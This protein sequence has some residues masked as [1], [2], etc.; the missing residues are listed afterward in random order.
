IGKEVAEVKSRPAKDLP[1][2]DEDY[3]LYK[4]KSGDT[5]W[6]IAKKFPGITDSDLIEL[7]DLGNGNS[8]KPGM[9]I[10]IKPK[11]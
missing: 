6:D 8:I 5:L 7:N 10:R 1:G 9:V 3:V 11:G 2:N 4:V